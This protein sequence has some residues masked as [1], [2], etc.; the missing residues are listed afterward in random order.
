MAKKVIDAR[1]S[2]EELPEK[3][4]L[5]PMLRRPI[6]V[7]YVAVRKCRRNPSWERFFSLPKLD[8]QT[9]TSRYVKKHED[10]LPDLK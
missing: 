2:K 4:G 6:Y 7:Q 10:G 5:P 1:K 9:L 8:R 3:P